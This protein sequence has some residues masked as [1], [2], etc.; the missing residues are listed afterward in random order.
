MNQH[1]LNGFEKTALSLGYITRGMLQG[2]K[3]VKPELDFMGN[4]PWRDVS[5]WAKEKGQIPR[6]QKRTLI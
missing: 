1:F 3:T 4:R 5:H 6:V 2:G